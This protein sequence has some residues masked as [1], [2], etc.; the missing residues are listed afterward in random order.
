MASTPDEWI[1]KLTDDKKWL[2]E[3]ELKT[4]CDRVCGVIFV[5]FLVNLMSGLTVAGSVVLGAG[6]GDS[7]R[8]IQRS[9]R[10]QSSML[11]FR[12]DLDYTDLALR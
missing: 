4:M 12:L 7:S 8:G 9:A 11:S 10:K 5:E 3:T 6:E 1:K 2:S